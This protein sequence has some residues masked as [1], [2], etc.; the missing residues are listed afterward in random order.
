MSSLV[1]GRIERHD[2]FV[3]A[4]FGG[5]VSEGFILCDVLS[6]ASCLVVEFWIA[7]CGACVPDGNVVAA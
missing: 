1:G 4:F 5:E 2:S 3:D 6:R 7:A